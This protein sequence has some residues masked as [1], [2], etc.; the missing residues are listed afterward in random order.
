MG[1]QCP[2]GIGDHFHRKAQPRAASR[3]ELWT[4]PPPRLWAAPPAHWR[5]AFGTIDGARQCL[6][7]HG[8][9]VPLPCGPR[10]HLSC[11][12]GPRARRARVGRRLP[13]CACPRAHR[14]AA[15]EVRRCGGFR[16]AGGRVGGGAGGADAFGGWLRAG[17]V[18]AAVR[19][20]APAESPTCSGTPCPGAG[21]A[22]T[23]PLRGYVGLWPAGG[24]DQRS[25][26]RDIHFFS[27]PPVS[28]MPC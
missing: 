22:P 4:G 7:F 10:R 27:S 11:S 15:R 17:A 23:G 26:P 18:V 28:G 2:T 21:D 24:E 6:A 9:D 3:T 5:T 20:G 25:V 13:D 16:A 19:V 8:I 14:P 12:R 1:D